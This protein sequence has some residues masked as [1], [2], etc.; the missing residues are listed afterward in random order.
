MVGA[1]VRCIK[2]LTNGDGH[3]LV[4]PTCR[5]FDITEGGALPDASELFS[6]EVV[7]VRA[8]A[9]LGSGGQTTPVRWSFQLVPGC[10]GVSIC[11]ADGQK[12]FKMLGGELWTSF[13]LA[14]QDPAHSSHTL[15]SCSSSG[16][17]LRSVVGSGWRGERPAVLVGT[18]LSGQHCPAETSQ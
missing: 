14:V 5:L 17:N 6:A 18:G 12:A 7:G 2:L 16:R 3:A 8:P 11:M 9:F 4:F 13:T 1:A 10:P 15:G